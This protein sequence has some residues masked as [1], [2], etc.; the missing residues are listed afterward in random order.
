[1]LGIHE[2][3]EADTADWKP[4]KRERPELLK[5]MQLVGTSAG[6]RELLAKGADHMHSLWSPRI[7]PAVRDIDTFWL[8]QRR[9]GLA[10]R[11]AP[12]H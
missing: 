7:A 3:S 4:L 8:H 12:M 9:R 10:T 5:P 2:G 6:F 1:M 11:S